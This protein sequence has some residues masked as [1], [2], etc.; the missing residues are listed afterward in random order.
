MPTTFNFLGAL[1]NPAHP[2][3]QAV[4]VADGRVAGLIA[5]VLAARGIDAL[6]FHGDDGLDELTTTT[7]SQVWSVGGGAAT[8]PETF[9][10]RELGLAAVEPAALRGADAAHNAGVVRAVLAGEPG[11]VHDVVLLNAA[12]ALA[13]YQPTAGSVTERLGVALTAAAA[14]IDSGAAR[15]TLDRWISTC[16]E[17]RAG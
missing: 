6:V 13:V 1:A 8:G 17:V 9:D 16:T 15:K 4:G 14:A 5:D 2:S 3:A 7:T 11:P 10:P 12:A